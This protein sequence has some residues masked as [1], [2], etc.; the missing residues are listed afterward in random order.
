MSAAGRAYVWGCSVAGDDG[1]IASTLSM[2]I[3]VEASTSEA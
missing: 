1:R 2:R 3:D